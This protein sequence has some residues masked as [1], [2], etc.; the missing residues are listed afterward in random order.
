MPATVTTLHHVIKTCTY[1]L[2]KWQSADTNVLIGWYWSS[3]KRPISI[4]G[5]LLVH[6]YF[7]LQLRILE[8]KNRNRALEEPAV[9]TGGHRMG[10]TPPWVWSRRVQRSVYLQLR[11]LRRK[12]RIDIEFFIK[13]LE[14]NREEKP[15]SSHHYVIEHSSSLHDDVWVLIMF[16]QFSSENSCDTNRTGHM[17]SW[18]NVGILHHF[19]GLCV[20]VHPVWFKLIVSVT[21]MWNNWKISLS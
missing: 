11:I 2:C 21:K 7:Y 5:R 6:F 15:Q 13:K 20:M 17:V 12:N 18:V 1:Q 14:A 4:I 3:S 16:S 8:Q 10:F 9:G 19:T